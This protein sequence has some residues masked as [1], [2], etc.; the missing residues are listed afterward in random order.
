MKVTCSASCPR[1]LKDAV[2]VQTH[3]TS[4]EALPSVVGARYRMFCE[5]SE[6]LFLV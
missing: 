4:A 1:I 6:K 3:R 5:K 2:I